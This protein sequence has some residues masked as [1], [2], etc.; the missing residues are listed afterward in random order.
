MVCEIYCWMTTC[1]LYPCVCVVIIILCC[2]CAHVCIKELCIWSCLFVCVCY[3]CMC[4]T[5]K[6]LFT[7]LPVKCLCEKGAYCSFIYIICRQRCL[8]DLLS[9]TESG[10]PFV[11]IHAIVPQRSSGTFQNIMVKKNSPSFRDCHTHWQLG[12]CLAW[13]DRNTRKPNTMAVHD[14]NCYTELSVQLCSL[15]VLSGHRV[16][17]LWNSSLLLIYISTGLRQLMRSRGFHGYSNYAIMTQKWEPTTL[18]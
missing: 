5:K 16:C 17:V 8:L 12:H 11:P 2:Y 6:H 4:V 10:I 9:C 18:V 3:M 13:L 1:S 14:W 15:T 7:H